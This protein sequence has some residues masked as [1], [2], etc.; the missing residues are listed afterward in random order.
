MKVKRKKKIYKRAN[1]VKI[2]VNF[3]S[4]GIQREHKPKGMNDRD[5][6]K[7]KVSKKV[8]FSFCFLSFEYKRIEASPMP[9]KTIVIKTQTPS[10]TSIV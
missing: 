1:A 3:I 9:H 10:R 6:P 2:K 4:I 8:Y 7:I 5:N